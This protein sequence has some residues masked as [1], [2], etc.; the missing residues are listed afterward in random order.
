MGSVGLKKILIE[1][2]GWLPARVRGARRV[3]S[4]GHFDEAA[5]GQVVAHHELTEIFHG[6]TLSAGTVC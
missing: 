2:A 4:G 6:I 3:Q 1:S 5:F